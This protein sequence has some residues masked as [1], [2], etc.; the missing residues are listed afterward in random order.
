VSRADIFHEAAKRFDVSDVNLS[1]SPLRVDDDAP[2][3]ISFVAE[4]NQRIYLSTAVADTPDQTSV[5]R[6]AVRA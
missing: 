3:T 5:R 1:L 2:T 4:I 6:Y